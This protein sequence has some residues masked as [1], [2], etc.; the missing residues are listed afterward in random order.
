MPTPFRLYDTKSRTVSDFTPQVP[1]TV[2]IYVC[3][4][5]VYDR[6]HVGHARA[7]V[8]FDAFT[9]WLRHEGWKVRFVRNFTDIDDKIIARAAT[10]GIDPAKLAQDEIDAFHADMAGLG[11]RPP[12]AEPRVTK[13]MPQIIE[14]IAA[15]VDGGHAYPSEGSVWFSVT[16]YERYGELSGRKREDMR[17]AD[18]ALG[19]RDP[20][21]FAL[22]K[23][24]K[25]GEPAWDSP[26]GP[27]RPGWHIECS[28]MAKHELGDTIDIHGGGLDLVFP[29]HENEIAQ[30]ECGNGKT[31]T[32]YWMHNGLL[33]MESGQKMGKSLGN[34]TPIE[35]VLREYPAEALRLYYLQNHYRSPLPWNAEAL[36]EALGMLSRLYD[37]RDVAEA[38]GGTEE[39]ADRVASEL[40]DDAKAVLEEGRAF[41]GRFEHSLR[42]DFNTSQ[43]LAHSFSLAR[44]V[45]RFGG[46]KKAR[47]R[48]APVVAPALAAFRLVAASLGLMAMDTQAFVE[49]VKD[50]RLSALGLRRE[51]VE[52]MVAQRVALREAKAWSEADAIRQRLDEQGIVVMD[53]PEGSRW[54]VRL[55]MAVEA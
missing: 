21:D 51:E 53:G 5:T 55:D 22:W 42:E 38:M 10:L 3:G 20:A 11:L 18:T 50:K 36:P 49:E 24:V 45:N 44:A 7:M 33:T 48:G 23:A 30:S 40:G 27:G 47:K 14:L 32:R 15:L 25:P 35:L 34:V 12:D 43:A 37:A 29:H 8:V 19:K 17:S 26:W 6:S 13:T 31:Y 16:S 28:A 1:G 9:R 46:H 52:A 54:R 39:D 2:G 41:P 4:M